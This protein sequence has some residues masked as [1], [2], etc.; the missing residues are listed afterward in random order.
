M[1]FSDWL[2]TLRRYAA[3]GR[4]SDATL[5]AAVAG[6]AA[7]RTTPAPVVNRAAR[8]AWDLL[9][10]GAV[11]LRHHAA[12]PDVRVYAG[13]SAGR[14][15][16]CLSLP[17]MWW[18]FVGESPAAEAGRLAAAFGF[19]AD[20]WAAPAA[21]LAVTAGGAPGDGPAVSF[22]PTADGSS[23]YVGVAE[24]SGPAA[25]ALGEA[26]VAGGAVQ[27]VALSLAHAAGEALS[28]PGGSDDYGP[29]PP[30]WPDFDLARARERYAPPAGRRVRP[31]AAYPVFGPEAVCGAG[32]VLVGGGLGL[33]RAG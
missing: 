22:R 1:T 30:G 12:A 6:L 23:P 21:A 15:A 10:S 31:P 19:L 25:V 4:G 32:P 24:F 18:G 3:T 33:A 13:V 26:V 8:L 11:D 17:A 16:A 14:V 5:R 9:A 7:E 20:L 28:P 27:R 29:A 2:D